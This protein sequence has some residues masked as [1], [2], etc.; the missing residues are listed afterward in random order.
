[1]SD[2]N[3]LLMPKLGLTMTEGLLAE[4]RV[5]PGAQVRPGDVLFVVETEKI[6]TEIE[7]TAEGRIE[8][9]LVEPG[10]TVPVGSPVALWTGPAPGGD[11][12][13]EPMAALPSAPVAAQPG[14]V[15]MP[16]GRI[17][18]TPL[19]RRLARQA[20][21]DLSA[22]R[23]SGPRGRIKA[24]DVE[25]ASATAVR[26][27][28]PVTQ[29]PRTASGSVRPPTTVE[30]IV[31]DRLS[32]SK[33]TIPHFYVLADADVTE[34]EHVRAELNADRS[35][36]RITIN[37]FLIAATAAALRADPGFACRWTEAGIEALPAGAVGI[38]V[39]TSRGLMV[40]VLQDAGTTGI[41]AIA[42]AA[43]HLVAR[44][45]DGRLSPDDM[46]GA[47]ISISNV[48]MTGASM[49][50]PI[51][52][53]DQSAILGVGA[54]RS[55]FRPDARGRPALR[56]EM[57]LVLSCDHR[58]HDGM[59]AARFLDRIVEALRHPVRAIRAPATSRG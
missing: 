2:G 25:A 40:P 3:P 26:A 33:R 49:L 52:D 6:A 41:E 10:Q 39:D 47:A 38:A 15:A 50:V 8:T 34:L 59:G 57:G 9:L 43:G 31:A 19:A 44:A 12:V 42:E 56:R 14:P 46:A 30:R 1:V 37:H 28:A 21:I 36:T 45:R 4:W 13:P 23:G 5:A 27:P 24:A 20:G 32:L 29:P 55:V 53:P 58:V 17:V 16:E 18:A 54:I 48:G 11:V 7:A 22:L 51:I 35:G